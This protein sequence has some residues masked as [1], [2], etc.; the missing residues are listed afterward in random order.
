MQININERFNV[1][2]DRKE[3]QKQLFENKYLSF[4]KSLN[5]FKTLEPD[6]D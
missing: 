2:N 3:Q 6:D 4:W 5:V 1:N